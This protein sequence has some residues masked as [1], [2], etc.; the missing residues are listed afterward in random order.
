MAQFKDKS[1]RVWVVELTVDSIKALRAN[2]KLDLADA[3][4]GDAIQRLSTD[5][6]LLVDAMYLI[7]AAQAKAEGI[8][9]AAFG[10]LFNGDA[11]GDAVD[12]LTQ[13]IVDFCRN[14]KARASL[15]E[16]LRLSKEAENKAID[17]VN[18]KLAGINL[19]EL[20]ATALRQAESKSG[21]S[22]TNAP[23]FSA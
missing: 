21:V 16:L 9:S 10:A 15:T 19:D 3:F 7:C 5:P 13:A 12:A 1:S 23:A 22:S 2:L 6:V 11:I 4:K 17:L 14:P 18:A 8:D 20:A